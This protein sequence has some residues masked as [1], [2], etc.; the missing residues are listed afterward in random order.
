MKYKRKNKSS[1]NA[2]KKG[3]YRDNSMIPNAICSIAAEKSNNNFE[4]PF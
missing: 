4:V 3:W 1:P 2:I